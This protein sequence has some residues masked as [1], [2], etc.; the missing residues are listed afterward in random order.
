MAA[1]SLIP[2]ALCALAQSTLQMLTEVVNG[3]CFWG[4]MLLLPRGHHS[5]L[6]RNSRNTSKN[7]QLL[8]Y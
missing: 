7:L 6:N 3:G 2:K 4:T 5:D 1:E 8:V